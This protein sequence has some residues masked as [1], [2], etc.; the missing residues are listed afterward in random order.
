MLINQKMKNLSLFLVVLLLGSVFTKDYDYIIAG[1]GTAGS[2][3]AALLS[4]DPE[5]KVLL[6]EQGDDNSEF[7]SD[8]VGFWNTIIYG[9]GFRI[10]EVATENFYV[11]HVYSQEYNLGLR[12]LPALAARLLGGGSSINGNAFSR[13]SEDDLA[14]WD[15]YYW[16]YNSTLN[17]WKALENCTGPAGTCDPLYHGTSGPIATNTF[18]LNS[19]VARIAEVLPDV[20]GVPANPDVNG[21]NATGVGKLPRNIAVVGGQPVRQDSWTRY[22]KPFVNRSNL[23]IKTG[24]KVLSIDY[25]ANGKHKVVYLHENNVYTDRAT[26]ETILSLGV[27]NTPKI[28]LLS[29][30]G[31]ADELAALGIECVVNNSHVGKNLQD[32]VL[33]SML[34]ASFEP[35]E[36]NPPGGILVGYYKSPQFT[37]E[38]T[39]MEVAFTQ[40]SSTGELIL[41]QLTQLRHN[42][43]GEVRLQ[44]KNPNMNPFITF[45]LYSTDADVDPLVDQFKKVR[46]AMF[47]ANRTL[48]EFYPGYDVVP[49]DASDAVIREW[50]KSEVTNEWH[51]IGTSSINKVVNGRLQ[52]INNVGAVVPRIR[53]IDNGAIPVKPRTHGTASG[54]MLIGQ[55][56]ARFILEDAAK[57]R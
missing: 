18:E 1:G 7:F 48:F 27:Y 45:N 34:Y 24:A 56:G 23:E 51:T 11:D 16:T 32:S 14:D 46:T 35:V 3:V 26:E 20:L 37:G 30:I 50:L 40:I 44:S 9:A 36:S 15:N 42:Q 28:L 33:A 43:L 5:K 38:G 54:A 21:R 12:S 2:V 53:I 6:L 41:V 22:L 31:P 49:P 13:F 29:G 55:V 57:R 52:L 25:K 39:D 19:L 47:L 10:N 8:I 17:D 4:V